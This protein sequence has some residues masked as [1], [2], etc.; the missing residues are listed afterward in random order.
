MIKIGSYNTLYISRFVDF[1]AYL[2]DGS[3]VDGRLTEVLMP[4]RYVSRKAVVGDQV[5]VFVYTDSEDRPV[6]TTEVPFAAVGEFAFLQVVAVNRTGAFMDWGLLKNLLCPY[7][8]QKSKMHAGGIYLVYI[9]L[10]PNTNRVVASAKINKF[11]GNAFPDYKAG[12]RVQALLIAHNDVGYQVIV[13]NKDRGIIYDNEI[14]VPLELQQ[15][16]SAY[17]KRVRDDGKLDLTMTMPG[18]G[19]RVEHLT[20]LILERLRGGDMHL[21]DKSSPQEIKSELHCSKKDFKKAVGALYR[22]KRIAIA[23]DG[24]LAL[25][26]SEVH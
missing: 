13:D 25:V 20:S 1:G 10:D 2:T 21:T 11:L 5:R 22:E 14:Y 9:Y 23:E 26:P 24:T 15:T 3:E 12:Q 4:A 17:V 16:V 7:G 19:N 18:T 6:A 8:E